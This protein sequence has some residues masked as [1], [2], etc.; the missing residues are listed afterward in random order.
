MPVVVI[1]THVFLRKILPEILKNGNN[2]LKACRRIVL[3]PKIVKE[4]TGRSRSHNYRMTDVLIAIQKLE[5][6][7]KL[8]KKSTSACEAIKVSNKE[9]RHD[10]HLIRAGKAAHAQCIVTR[11]RKH[12]LN[13]RIKIKREFDIE[14]VTPDRFFE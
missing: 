2:I 5:T 11:D 7:G 12:L 9:V 13:H 8:V 10:A 3:S 4:Y 1:D 6:M 14:V